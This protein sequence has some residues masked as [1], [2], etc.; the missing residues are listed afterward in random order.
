MAKEKQNMNV[1]FVGHVDAGKSTIV[2]RTMFDSGAVSEQEMKKLKEE[3]QKHGK[4]GF[5]FA[6]VMDHIKEER[7]RGVTIDLA[8][9]KIMTQKFQITIIDA[10]GHRDFVKN[11][12]TGASQADSAFLVIAGKS[13]VQPQTKEHLWLLRTAGIKNI[14]VA[15]N[16]M[17]E[18]EYSEDKFN[19]V[20][21]DVSK[22]LKGVGINPET[23]QFL[24]VSGL[25]GDNIVNKSDKMAWYKG[26]TILEQFDKFPVPELPTNL[27]M[28]MPVQDAYEITGIGTV[29]VG[30]I[31]TGVM[32]IGQKVKVLP[33]RTGEGIEGEVKTI[34]AH[35][36]QLQEAV[37]GDNVGI[38]VRG[39]GKKDIARGD[40]ICDAKNPIPIAKEFIATIT[41]INH[42]SVLAKGYTPVFHVHTGQ[43]PCQF[44][45]LIA[46]INPGTGEVIKEKPDFLKNGDAARV[47]IKP[48]GNLAIETQKD[49]PA[50]SR[51]SIRDAGITVA[52]GM[53]TEIT[54][55]K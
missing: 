2:G 46:Q 18:L 48:Q 37:A 34:E 53:C 44:T 13:G 54:E 29:P 23:T 35:H 32:K 38:N 14:S 47:K 28:R 31:V 8:Y 5:E 9:K 21:E 43:V 39:V 33:G 4:V 24:A 27:P 55:K 40:V 52:A 10:P 22:E 41:V 12:I 45:E 17:D 49:N 1:V 50:M 20:K 11:M 51:F 30:K 15:I 16:K 25:Q 26:P 36:E 42:P 19:K 6:Y 7:E 3:A